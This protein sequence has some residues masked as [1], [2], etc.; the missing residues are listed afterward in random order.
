MSDDSP[1][2]ATSAPGSARCAQVLLVEDTRVNQMVLERF[3]TGAG[4]TVTLASDGDE[5]L[6]II[7]TQRRGAG[8][9][10][11]L[12]DM[13][14]PRVD[15][16]TVVRA[17]R[18][19]GDRTPVIALTASSMPGDREGCIAAGCTDYLL[20]PVTRMTLLEMVQRHL[21]PAI[22]PAR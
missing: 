11:V 22:D 19:F 10:V 15:G 21:A 16:Y 17:M 18:E 5:A 3:L 2:G 7:E 6:D 8:F 14:M 12:L 20:K 9:D 4:H 13:H 1:A